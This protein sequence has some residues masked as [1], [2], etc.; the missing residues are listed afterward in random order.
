MSVNNDDTINGRLLNVKPPRPSLI[1]AAVFG[2]I[3]EK[4]LSVIAEFVGRDIAL[5]GLLNERI[6]VVHVTSIDGGI[7][8]AVIKGTGEEVFIAA[9]YIVFVL[10]TTPRT[11][12]GFLSRSRGCDFILRLTYPTSQFIY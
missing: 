9:R 3:E 10:R 11:R 7:I 5:M 1:D 4:I 2:A 12:K 6:T 8:G